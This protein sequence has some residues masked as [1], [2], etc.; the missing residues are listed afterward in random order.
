MYF[1]YQK[2]FCSKNIM[3][4]YVLINASVSQFNLLCFVLQEMYQMLLCCGMS[5]IMSY[6]VQHVFNFF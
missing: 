1:W 6:E 5:T 4:Q 3:D 2:E